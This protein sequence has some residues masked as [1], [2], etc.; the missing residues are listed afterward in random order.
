MLRLRVRFTF[1]LVWQLYCEINNIDFLGSPSDLVGNYQDIV[2][3]FV[4]LEIRQNSA[5]TSE[6]YMRVTCYAGKNFSYKKILAVYVLPKK[7]L[8]FP[9]IPPTLLILSMP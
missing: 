6:N 1:A 4:L 7:N 5:L 3:S 8:K 9:E 2:M